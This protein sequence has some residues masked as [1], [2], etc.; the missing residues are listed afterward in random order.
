MGVIGTTRSSWPG[1]NIFAA[2]IAVAGL[3]A[4]PILLYA[5]LGPSDGNPIGLGLLMV[6]A[7]PAGGLMAVIGLIK[8]LIE[9]LVGRF[10]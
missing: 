8:M 5:L 10:G 3:G 6:V 9:C 2:G 1:A 4:L 7:V